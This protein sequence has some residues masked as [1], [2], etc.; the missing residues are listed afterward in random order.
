MI[1]KLIALSLAGF[2]ANGIH[3]VNSG[4]MMNRPQ[5]VTAG[6]TVYVSKRVFGQSTWTIDS[7]D[8]SGKETTLANFDSEI[9]DIKLD[10]STA[11]VL[12]SNELSALNLK[13][14]KIEKHFTTIEPTA[15]YPQHN[16]ASEM[17]IVNGL[18]YVAHGM[19]GIAVLDLKNGKLLQS[20]TLGLDHQAGGHISKV[21]G[22]SFDGTQ[23]IAIADS[24]TMASETSRAFNGILKV[25]LADLSVSVRALSDEANA[26]PMTEVLS[27]EVVGN[28]LVVDNWGIVNKVDLAALHDGQKFSA[29]SLVSKVVF[30]GK[31][32]LPEMLGD[33]LF[34][35]T[36]FVGCGKISN[37]DVANHIPHRTGVLVTGSL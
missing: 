24:V 33:L 12:T 23:L 7:I 8:A 37:D 4:W 20:S 30:E 10:G 13:S 5:I 36:M 17:V 35:G 18:A 2:C 22:V 1:S 21:V 34:D 15:D 19:H 32:Y 16:R 29:R 14:G 9:R 28:F 3:Q 6:D 25:N 31:S 27:S 11:W 26:S